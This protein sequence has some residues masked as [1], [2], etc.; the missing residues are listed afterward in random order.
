MTPA[1]AVLIG[2][3]V[4]L[5]GVVLWA[6]SK[7]R[8]AILAEADTLMARTYHEMTNGTL[9]SVTNALVNYVRYV[10]Q[11]ERALKASRRV[12]IMLSVPYSQLAYIC[13]SVGETN[14]AISSLKSA[15]RYHALDRAEEG[16]KPLSKTDFAEH[17][18]NDGPVWEARF[19]PK[20]RAG[21]P[22]MTGAVEQVRTAF[23][24]ADMSGKEIAQRLSAADQTYRTNDALRAKLA[25]LDHRADL[26]R[27][28]AAEIKGI[29]YDFCLATVSGRLF[30]LGEYLG[31]TNLASVSYQESARHFNAVRKATRQSPR[32]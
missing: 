27:W 20:W 21:A 13:A 12:G 22:P 18:M 4:A 10:E 5:S 7:K 9:G 1:A 14:A 17:I 32:E 29:D 31:D 30:A 15:Y 11:N 3:A 23:T 25:L 26:E 6:F 24:A 28:K 2:L 8:N 19:T 16:L